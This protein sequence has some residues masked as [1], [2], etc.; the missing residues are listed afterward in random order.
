M[1]NT[2]KTSPSWWQR[3]I[4][5]V[6]KRKRARTFVEVDYPLLQQRLGYQFRH[7]T[8]LRQALTHRSFANE[9]GDPDMEDNE[10]FEFLGDSVMGFVI[11]DLLYQC[12]PRFREGD[13]SRV[14]SHVVSEPFLAELARELDLGSF[15]LLG[16]G[17]SYSG[18]HEKS[19]LLSNCYEALIAAIYLDGGIEPARE[20]IVAAF[21]DRVETLVHNRHILDHKSLLQEHAQDIFHCTPH[22]RMRRVTGPDHERTYEIDLMIKGE[23]FSTGSGKNRKEAEQSAAKAALAKLNISEGKSRA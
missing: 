15:M 7:L 10:K 22:Y 8:M 20:F 16:R 6:F 23:V 9:S 5:R 11:S 21:K 17:E 3:L 19:S 4:Q 2:S 12:F 1:E 18:G 13:L 14:K